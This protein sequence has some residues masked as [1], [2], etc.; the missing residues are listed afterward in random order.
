[1]KKVFAA[2]MLAAMLAAWG[3]STASNR[4]EGYGYSSS[5]P[6]STT[7]DKFEREKATSSATPF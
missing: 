3:C 6:D 2:L 5:R 7:T 1:M 4:D